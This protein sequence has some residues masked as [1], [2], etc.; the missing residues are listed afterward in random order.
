M[1]RCCLRLYLDRIAR[2][3][4]MAGKAADRNGQDI[5]GHLHQLQ[6]G[7]DPETLVTP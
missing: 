7:K 4:P 6:Q 1:R 2:G 3:M 5:G